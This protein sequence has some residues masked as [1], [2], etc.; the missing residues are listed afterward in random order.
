M[1]NVY[2]TITGRKLDLAQLAEP[3]RN[4]LREARA[5]VGKAGGW[6]RFASWWL[7]A[8]NESGLPDSSL[9]FRVCRD[10]EARLGIAEGKVAWPDY[11]DY[12]ADLIEEHFDSRYRFC[13]ATGID[14]GQLSR[15]FAAK[16]DLSADLLRTALK[17]LNAHLEVRPNVEAARAFS[18][19]E[20]LE[21]LAE[22]VR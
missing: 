3:E 4:L 22:A 12:L 11:R 13:E 18:R 1:S 10:L 21:A 17:A 20:A 15:V 16:A 2:L 19:E 5:R 9:V 14:P 6:N 7:R 8:F